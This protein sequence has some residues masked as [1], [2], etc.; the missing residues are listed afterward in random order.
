ME[1]IQVSLSNAFTGKAPKEIHK[2]K[3]KDY[4]FGQSFVG[5]SITVADFFKHITAGNAWAVGT[6]KDNRRRKENFIQSQVL[7]LDLDNP[8][9]YMAIQSELAALIHPTPSYTLDT[10]KYRVIFILDSPITNCEDW[11]KAQR[12]CQFTY[13]VWNPDTST[14]DG[15]RFFFG[16]SLENPTTRIYPS[17]RVT[18]EVLQKWLDL[19]D[20]HIDAQLEKTKHIAPDAPAAGDT[21]DLPQA[22][23]AAVISGLG[24]NTHETNSAGFIRQAVRCPVARHEHDG[25]APALHWHPAKNFAHCFKCGADYNTHQLADALSIDT[26]P[27]Y[28][29]TDPPPP[30]PK[31][32]TIPKVEVVPGVEAV[33]ESSRIFQERVTN[34]SAIIGLRSGITALDNRLGGFAPGGCYTF[35]GEAG[36]GKTT[37]CS[38][39]GYWFL[40][41]GKGIILSAETRPSDFVDKLIAYAIKIP[42]GDIR[43]AGTLT[44]EIDLKRGGKVRVYRKFDKP[45]LEEIAFHRAH[46]LKLMANNTV[47]IPRGN[48]S[49]D[50]IRA[51]YAEHGKS[52]Q[53][54]MIDSLNNIKI[55]GRS[56]EYEDV[57]EASHMGEALS[58]DYN[59]PI[60]ATGQGG[61][62]TKDRSNKRLK[63]HDARGSGAVEEKGFAVIGIYNPWHLAALGEIDSVPVDTPENQIEFNILKLRD[64]VVGG[65]VPAQ[66]IGGAGYYNAS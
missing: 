56:S 30:P 18:G 31:I 50:Y 3:S 52:S 16:A 38:S 63:L 15:A 36:T 25:T 7:V 6:Y 17:R 27:Y 39:I 9:E 43:R 45:A 57:T 65:G 19:Y 5:Q 33:K 37:L 11:E 12:A 22:L 40:G 28:T 53:W 62:N 20:A 26:A 41:Q 51:V 35:L 1:T 66:F 23:I 14:R 34:P 13:A 54:G 44:E 47:F 59:L 49:P 4:L 42:Y 61:R 64:G 24:V 60:I 32:L 46:L 48:P 29:Q 58:V 10:P 8:P 55:P 2:T 21:P